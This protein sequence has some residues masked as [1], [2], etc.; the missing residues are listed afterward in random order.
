MEKYIWLFPI[1]FIFHDM[2]EIIGLEKWINKYR[3]VLKNKYPKIANTYENYSTSKMALAVFE[4]FNLS[5]LICMFSLF[6]SQYELWVGV[7]IAFI[8]HLFVHIIQA[9]FF[10]KY[11]PALITSIIAIPIS[12]SILIKCILILNYDFIKIALFREPLIN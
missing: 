6:F 1:L 7:F 3:D 12:L 5:V 11:I 2:E 9:I 4:E 8:L 10:G